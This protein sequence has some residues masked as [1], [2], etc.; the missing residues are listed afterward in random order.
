MGPYLVSLLSQPM[1]KWGQSQ[2]S[3][4]GRLLGLL[5]PYHR[6]VIGT[7]NTCLRELTH[8]SLTN[9]G[10]G[11]NREGVNFPHTTLRLFQPMALPFP[12]KGPARSP[13]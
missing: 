3:V 1:K 2:P 4:D 9:T 13:V 8:W 6:H 5:G 10:G 7:L 11:Y 12:P